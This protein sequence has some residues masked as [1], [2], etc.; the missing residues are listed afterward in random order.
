M[1]GKSNL[2][3]LSTFCIQYLI[4][5]YAHFRTIDHTICSF[6]LPTEFNASGQAHVIDDEDKVKI[7]VDPTKMC[8]DGIET[9]QLEEVVD[10]WFKHVSKI[11][12]ESCEKVIWIMI[13]VFVSQ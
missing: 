1:S 13:E 7:K 5:L 12:R 6:N 10:G 2:Q 9:N 4:F 11:F 3:I 8:L